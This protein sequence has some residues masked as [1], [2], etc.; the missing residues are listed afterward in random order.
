MALK[1]FRTT[2][3]STL[4]M[5][6]ETRVAPH[7][8]RLVLRGSLWLAIACNVGVWRLLAHGGDWR[9]A[10]ASVLLIGGA[11]GVVLSLFGWRRTLKPAL[12]LAFLA[13]AVLATGLWSQQLPIASAWQGPPSTWLPGWTSFMRWQAL[14][15]LFLLAVVPIVSAWNA[16]ARRLSGP[17]QLKSNLLGA[18]LAAAVLAIGVLLAH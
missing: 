7:P 15:L 13:G 4:L 6:G 14:A 12:T 9:E 18:G 1:L 3:Y 11:S 17:A 16:Q 5:P 8:A 2:G 10:I